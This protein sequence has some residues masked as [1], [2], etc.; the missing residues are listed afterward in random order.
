MKPKKY[1]VYLF[2]LFIP[3]LKTIPDTITLKG[4]KTRSV[5]VQSIN[6][7]SVTFLNE[8]GKTEILKKKSIARIIRKDKTGNE[9]D[10]ILQDEFLRKEEKLKTEMEKE[11]ENAIREEKEKYEQKL[12]KELENKKEEITKFEKE[13][14]E[15]QRKVELER[16]Q[17]DREKAFEAIK[18][19]KAASGNSQLNTKS[20]YDSFVTSNYFYSPSN[21]I[22]AL[23]NPETNCE[24]ISDQ[25]Q[26]FILFGTIP[27]NKVKSTDIFTKEGQYRVYLK[28]SAIDIISS[29][30][31]AVMTSVTVKTVFIET[32]HVEQVYLLN[33]NEVNTLIHKKTE[34]LE[35]TTEEPLKEE[36]IDPKESLTPDTT[37]P[38]EEKVK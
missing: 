26:W 15:E 2:L 35:T 16:D 12:K 3:F 36:K 33:E 10:L 8:K 22:V 34:A 24:T 38:M 29:I 21:S 5:K 1:L 30:F 31:L 4:G 13:K 37:K 17:R 25:K 18:Q 32:C 7:D 20:W 11:K 27:I 23:A 6:L 9:N 19:K 28:P 14:Y